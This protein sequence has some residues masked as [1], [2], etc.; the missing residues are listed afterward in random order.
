V[1][2]KNP[3][4][5]PGSSADRSGA[6]V[7]RDVGLAETVESVER[8][9][10]QTSGAG[11]A[12][13]ATIEASAADASSPHATLTASGSLELEH[14]QQLDHFIVMDKLGTG[15]MGVVVAAYDPNLDRRVAIKVLRP[16][17]GEGGSRERPR[18]RLL[19]EAQA[20]ARL[21][22]PN[23][24]TVHEV[25]T[26]GN[27]VF[28]A[29]EYVEGQTLAVWLTAE[30]RPWREVLRVFREAGAGL[31]AAHDAGMVHRDFKPEN[32]LIGDDGRVC[33]TDFG[34]VSSAGK[35]AGE[36]DEDGAPGVDEH[37]SVPLSTSL[38]RTG[39]L[40]GTPNYMAPEQHARKPVDARAD[41][42]A[43]CVALYEALY[44]ERP[45][46]GDSYWDLA[47]SV[48]SGQIKEPAARAQ[49][50]AWVRRVVVRGLRAD[51]DERFPSMGE[52]LV[53]LSKDP[54]AARRRRLRIAGIGAAFA[55]LSAAAVFGVVRYW[56]RAP[57]A[58]AGA[59]A[60]LASIWNAKARNGLENVF[61]ETGTPYSADAFA[62]AAAALDEYA[63]EWTATW[64]AAC[65]ATRVHGTQSAALLDLRMH[66]LGRL[67]ARMAAIVGVLG[68]RPDAT[69]VA[70][71]V[72]AVDELPAVDSCD[73]VDALTTVAP[74]PADADARASV[75][76]IASRLAEARALAAVGRQGE[77]LT[78]VIAAIDDA[79]AAKHAPILAEALYVLGRLQD[80]S[81]RESAA[82]KALDEAVQVAAEARNDRLVARTWNELVY[83]VGARQARP[84]D[85]LVL[86]RTAEAAVARAGDGS[87][88][89]AEL[90]H[91]LGDVFLSKGDFAEAQHHY[92]PALSL[93]IELHGEASPMVAVAA[94]DL[95]RALLDG[96]KRAA[97]RT[98]YERSL[99]AFEQSLGP[100]HP[101]TTRARARLRQLDALPEQPELPDPAGSPQ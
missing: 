83:V 71:A 25:G 29:M 15:G 54:E 26:V 27:R 60:Q 20:M 1:T 84:D 85:A 72:Q 76:A 97:A 43:F 59:R 41:Q 96:G 30:Q 4:R 56:T 2:G 101:D 65:Q 78:L 21:S 7:D 34:L 16:D 63:D 47:S 39:T 36:L 23:V 3:P 99:A 14:G 5:R 22:H 70:R 50:P 12:G 53:E 6:G 37:D 40:L 66:C 11:I 61:A 8:A 31:A 19:R 10:T 64:T 17:V 88:L 45:F 42:F 18:Q 52:L 94:A 74:P 9:E 93:L 79:R 44:G 98:A 91:N 95:G 69:A 92:E 100:E 73:D 87:D 32:V 57:E 55:V 35:D 58:C 68:S 81:G 75:E 33:V 24:V 77:G 13:D 86:R 90:E 89:R 67:R 82:K 62:R 49:V 48:T 38:T 46:E 51:P 28:V 80:L